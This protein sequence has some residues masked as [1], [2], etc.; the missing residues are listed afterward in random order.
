MTGEAIE[1]TIS[2]LED[3]RYRAM[4]SSDIAAL[5]RLLAD[6][7]VLVHSS[8]MADDKK[9][10]LATLSS[11]T[12]TYG[13]IERTGTK[14]VPHGDNA[15]VVSGRVWMDAVLNGRDLKLDNII[16]A[17]WVRGENGW[18]LASAQSTPIP[19]QTAG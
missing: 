17:L 12:L 10:Y 14:I 19:P 2:G 6:T 11:G 1:T 16:L 15:A 9:A 5:D 18:Q 13:R 8:A 3:E 4:E 7:M